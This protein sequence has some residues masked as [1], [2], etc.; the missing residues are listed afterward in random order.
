MASQAITLVYSMIFERGVCC[1]ES[2]GRNWR[3]TIRALNVAVACL[4]CTCGHT[5]LELWIVPLHVG[6]RATYSADFPLKTL[7]GEH[8]WLQSTTC[9]GWCSP[10]HRMLIEHAELVQVHRCCTILTVDQSFYTPLG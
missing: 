4:A 1:K 7:N 8:T 5:A 9:Y 6:L 2:T 3:G 10:H